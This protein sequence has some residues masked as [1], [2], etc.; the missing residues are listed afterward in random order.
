MK[1]IKLRSFP[2]KCRYCGK[3]VLYWE[4]TR[5]AK[6]FFNLPIYGRPIRHH[7]AARYSRKT[8][9]IKETVEDHLKKKL[10]HISFQCP[11]CGKIY[12]SESALNNHF[13]QTR[14][15]D[16]QHAEFLEMLD[17]MVLDDDPLKNEGKTI[18]SFKTHHKLETVR[19]RYIIKKRGKSEKEE[20]SHI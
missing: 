19:D 17:F 12:N 15:Y 2:T 13:K 3:S 11:V 8:P 18:P 14:K 7:C 10:E 1:H 5:G 20:K 9:M 6:V 4:S 16:D